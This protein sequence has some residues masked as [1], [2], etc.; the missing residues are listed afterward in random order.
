[1]IIS[2]RDLSYE[3]LKGKLSKDDKVLLWSCNT[4]IKFCGVGGYDNMV[5]LED[6][7]TADGYEVVGKELVSIACMYSLAEQ[8][9]D[10][11]N[12]KEL[13]DEATA[14]IVLA[15]E[16]GYEV[17]EAAFSDKK[18]IKIVKT[19][20][21]GNFTMDRGPVLTA[22]FE[23]TGLEQTDNGYSF[24]EVAEKL[25]LYPT[26]FG[27]NEAAKNSD[28]GF[29]SVTINGT[30]YKVRKDV[31][32]MQACEENG[33]KIPHLCN[34]PDLTP[35]ANCRLCLVKVKGER[36][37]VPACATPVKE[38]MEIVTED[39]ELNHNRRILLELQMAAHEHNCLTCHKGNPCIAGSCELQ[40]LIRDFDIEE[41]RYEQNKEKL[42]VDKTSPVL[43]YD[44]NKCILCG[45]CV[46]ACREIACQN[47][48]GFV[49][50]GDKTF[51]A[52]GA[53]KTFDQ[54]PCVTCL[55]CV[56]ACPTGAI[57]EKISHFDG[58]NWDEE[59]IFQS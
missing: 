27:R 19:V 58:D 57:T 9:R 43:V 42:P 45:R 56:F 44:P 40:E 3:E 28:D 46:R 23:T 6:M 17:A 1:M 5:L 29:I 24:P 14:I 37:L 2:L 54:S 38:N 10:D 21:V 31:N 50:R 36:E 35:D 59:L 33:I 34:E 8:H 30:Q 15:C 49:N 25:N 11:P 7:L 12:K 32:I 20:G 39:D 55:A 52:A 53:N 41:S 16:D 26:F 51:V 18:V 13:F 47:N 48:L 4:C 22:P